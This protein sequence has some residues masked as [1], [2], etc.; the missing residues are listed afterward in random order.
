MKSYFYIFLALAFILLP[1]KRAEAFVIFD[2]STKVQDIAEKVIE[3]AKYASER[4]SASEHKLRDSKLGKM[5]AKAHEHYTKLNK[6]LIRDRKL[7]C[8]L[9]TSDAADD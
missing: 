2:V 8:L 9:Y 6:F 4:I 3:W 1:S 7:G 5:G